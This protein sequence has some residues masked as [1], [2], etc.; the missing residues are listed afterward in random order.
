MYPCG[1]AA[2][3]GPSESLLTLTDRDRAAGGGE[4]KVCEIYWAQLSRVLQ[5]IQAF[6]FF[7]GWSD[8]LRNT[9]SKS[10]MTM[11]GTVS[12]VDQLQTFVIFSQ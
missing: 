10:R 2:R 7:F 4:Q 12:E 6:W 1:N 11:K 5:I 3:D 9:K 8:F